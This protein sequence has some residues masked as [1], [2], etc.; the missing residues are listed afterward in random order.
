VS[1][2]LVY[3]FLSSVNSVFIGLIEKN[4]KVALLVLAGTIATHICYGLSFIKGILSRK[5]SACKGY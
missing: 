4:I 5:L 2:L 3:F 1:L